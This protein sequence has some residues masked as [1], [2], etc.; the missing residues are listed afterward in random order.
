MWEVIFRKE[1][2]VVESQRGKGVSLMMLNL[3]R[4]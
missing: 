2:V 1:E 3:S 4:G